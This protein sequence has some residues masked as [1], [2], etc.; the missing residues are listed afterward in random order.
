MP[1]SA[2]LLGTTMT[3]T[4]HPEENRTRFHLEGLDLVEGASKTTLDVDLMDRADGL[5]DPKIKKL[6]GSISAD[7][8]MEVLS[9]PLPGINFNGAGAT[10]EL[11]N[12]QMDLETGSVHK[13]DLKFR[14]NIDKADVDWGPRKWISTPVF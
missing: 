2:T 8:L 14:V 13:G 1:E 10:Y 7:V 6:T 9:L 4:F 3:V 5:V 11:T 12:V